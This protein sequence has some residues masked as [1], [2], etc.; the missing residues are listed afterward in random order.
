MR[1]PDRAGHSA[2][3]SKI[4][5]KQGL[6]LGAPASLCSAPHE[7][8]SGCWDGDT[9]P[10][11]V[12]PGHLCS[13]C[14][15]L[16]DSGRPPGPP[17]PE[18]LCLGWAEV[19]WRKRLFS[20]KEA[21]QSRHLRAAGRSASERPLQAGLWFA[22]KVCFWPTVLVFV[23]INSWLLVLPWTQNPGLQLFIITKN[24]FWIQL[25]LFV[26]PTD[27]LRLEIETLCSARTPPMFS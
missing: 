22:S 12:T 1:T 6:W 7:H 9:Q 10:S 4:Q 2:L 15:P 20:S 11:A 8:G 14:P 25:W 24:H 23:F 3:A 13:V 19:L 26:F 17:A 18:G 5:P 21:F 27:I 16:M